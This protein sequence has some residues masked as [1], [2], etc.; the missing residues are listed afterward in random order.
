M[1]EYNKILSDLNTDYIANSVINKN[2]GKPLEEIYDLIQLEY[3]K[4]TSTYWLPEHT[5]IL[6]PAI[7]EKIASRNYYTIN[8]ALIRPNQKYLDYHALLVDITSH[9]KYVLKHPLKFELGDEIPY[10]IN[11]LET[12]EIKNEKEIGIQRVRSKK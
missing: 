7:K 11:Q 5:I 3:Y 6:Y 1:D 9:S 12:L 2:Y 4:H 8:N 10:T